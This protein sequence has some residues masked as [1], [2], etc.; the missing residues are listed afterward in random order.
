MVSAKCPDRVNFDNFS[1]LLV[2][3]R[4]I[5]KVDRKDQ[6]CATISYN[7]FPN[8]TLRYVESHCSAD[9]VLESEE[10]H[11]IAAAQPTNDESTEVAENE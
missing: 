8:Q 10:C 6:T 4:N 1:E 7:D 3:K 2:A 9:K 5:V 11:F